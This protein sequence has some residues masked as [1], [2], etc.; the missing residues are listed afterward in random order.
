MPV[1]ERLERRGGL[2]VDSAFT[3]FFRDERSGSR[4][5]T[6]DNSSSAAASL[7]PG[8][9]G[10]LP[11]FYLIRGVGWLLA[12]A[13]SPRSSS[14]RASMQSLA[15]AGQHGFIIQPSIWPTLLALFPYLDANEETGRQGADLLGYWP[16]R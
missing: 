7:S 12:R 14:K 4:E 5:L 11:L 13:F 3:L 15:V 1:T 16:Y 8:K 9:M 6:E 2:F 10:S